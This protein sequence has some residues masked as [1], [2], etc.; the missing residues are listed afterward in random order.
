M[1]HTPKNPALAAIQKLGMQRKSVERHRFPGLDMNHG[2]VKKIQNIQMEQRRQLALQN[3]AHSSASCTP[4]GLQRAA[5]PAIQIY[6]PPPARQAEKENQRDQGFK[7]SLK[8]EPLKSTTNHNPAAQ[9]I[10]QLR[11]SGVKDHVPAKETSSAAC[12]EPPARSSQLQSKDEDKQDTILAYD[13]IVKQALQ[14][15]TTLK[16]KELQWL[17][18]HITQT[19]T[20]GAKHAE[21][22]AKF[23][24]QI[25]TTVKNGAFVESLLN[26]CCELFEQREQLMSPPQT[27]GNVSMLWM[28]CVTF[29]A[30]LLVEFW[31]FDPECGADAADAVCNKGSHG[32]SKGVAQQL[33]S[34][35]CNCFHAMLRPSSLGSVA[36]TECLRSA[37]TASGRAMQNVQPQLTSMLMKRVRDAFFEPAISIRTKKILEELIELRSS[38]WQMSLSQQT[39]YNPS[40]F[41]QCRQ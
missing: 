8:C 35:L 36:E 31:S 3:A 29:V 37:M 28:P 2:F 26:S 15:P 9:Q 19:A 30:K 24:H 20:R 17:A 16:P 39:Y 41:L 11:R 23:C 25:A 38:G 6:R 40:K 13:S 10:P 27:S 33:A 34:L 12:G 7:A 21:D 4:A 18:G 22:A 14:D 5:K 32:S 1:E